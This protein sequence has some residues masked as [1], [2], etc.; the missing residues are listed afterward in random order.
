MFQIK[1]AQ[2][3]ADSFMAFVKFTRPAEQDGGQWCPVRVLPSA[4]RRVGTGG[5]GG[6]V[7]RV[8]SH[9]PP[10]RAEKVRLEVTYSAENVNL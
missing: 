6:G 5:G 9:P 8:R 2:Y 10:P 4:S 1:H 7:R 3:A